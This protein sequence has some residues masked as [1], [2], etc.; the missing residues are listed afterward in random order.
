MFMKRFFP[1]SV[2]RFF[3]IFLCVFCLVF[4]V[5]W[6]TKRGVALWIPASFP[7]MAIYPELK[8]IKETTRDFSQLTLYF[9]ELA[10]QKGSI[11]AFEVLRKASLPPH[12]D[13]HLLGHTVG[14][15]LY[16]EQGVNGIKVCTNDFRNACSHSIVVGLF[17][18][19][20]E[21]ALEEI[22][23]VCRDAPGG[24]GAYTMCFHGLGHGVVAYAG[25][26][27]KRAIV[28]CE[29]TG[30]SAY[31]NREAIECIG[32]TIMEM[33]SGGFHNRNLWTKQRNVYFSRED[34]L[35]LCNK[36]FVPVNAKVQC[37]IYLTPYLWE[38]VGADLGNPSNED[39]IQSFRLCDRVAVSQANDRDACFGGF[40][41][42][43]V[44][45]VQGRDIRMS[46][47]AS[48][49]EGQLRQIYSWCNLS[50]DERGIIMCNEHALASLYW[51]GETDRSIAL[52][53]CSI[54]D[55]K[56]IQDH[57]FRNLV[58]LVSIYIT[59]MQYRELFCGE[60]P[61]IYRQ[62]CISAL[63]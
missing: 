27:L 21:Q 58:N 51:G 63:L 18:D 1:H 15:V 31:G 9:K 50:H 7:S 44:G 30:T 13:M 61:P 17:F 38:A 24:K 23:H 55:K 10:Q 16:K 11:Y 3:F 33:I 6:I 40:G 59:N 56:S 35:A 46:S 2:V 36:N 28:L 20:G 29:K 54:I 32:G 49:G 45:L 26:D 19:K 12:T 4:F 8:E 5:I 62:Q 53:F 52:R 25:Y 22:A 34:P 43:F 39:F 48:I 41:K 37:Y 42:E 60:L 14:D 47:I 57:C